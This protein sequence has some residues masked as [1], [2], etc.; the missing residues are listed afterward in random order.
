MSPLSIVKYFN[1]FKHSIFCFCSCLIGLMFDTLL[2]H[3]SKETLHKR[4][5]ITIP[6][7]AH[8]HLYLSCFEHSQIALTRILSFLSPSD[9]PDQ[10]LA[11]VGSAPFLPLLCSMLRLSRSEWPIP[12]PI[13]R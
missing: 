4:I 12:R 10:I 3:C 11:C 9:G 6:F 7:S 5:I 2:F 1:I 8:A 13:S